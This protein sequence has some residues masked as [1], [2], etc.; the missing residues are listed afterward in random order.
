MCTPRVKSKRHKKAVLG[1]SDRRIMILPV[2]C[3][4]SLVATVRGR[5]EQ[6][7]E[8]A[9]QHVIDLRHRH[10][11]AEVRKTR[12]PETRSA[13]PTRH[14]AGEMGQVRVHIQADAVECNEAPHLDADGGDFVLAPAWSRYP[15]PD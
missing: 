1:T 5:P 7:F 2:P 6:R 14:D 9:A 13:D 3:P 12:Y 15:D 11:A 4:Q 10:P 8:L